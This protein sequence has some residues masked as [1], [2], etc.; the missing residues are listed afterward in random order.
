M[1]STD[2]TNNENNNDDDELIEMQARK[3]R[4]MVAI[5]EYIPDEED[6]EE[7]EEGQLTGKHK[8]VVHCEVKG[9][10]VSSKA[11]RIYI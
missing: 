3:S 2:P 10:G 11:Y 4:P 6:D 9:D 5:T 8:E 7:L 1:E